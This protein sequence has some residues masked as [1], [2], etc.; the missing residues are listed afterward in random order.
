MH[1]ICVI[2]AIRYIPVGDFLR[3]G[4]VPTCL[5]KSV[6]KFK[7]SL[8]IVLLLKFHK[9][10]A[11]AINQPTSASWTSPGKVVDIVLSPK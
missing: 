10:D 8:F 5:H 4:A 7:K 9:I 11:V 2:R 1:I 3:A 6:G